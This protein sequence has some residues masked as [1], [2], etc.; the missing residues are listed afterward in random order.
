MSD[1]LQLVV[2]FEES[3]ARVSDKLKHIGHYHASVLWVAVYPSN[4]LAISA[5]TR[6]LF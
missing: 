1:M 4:D 6:A 3:P 5:A 2:R